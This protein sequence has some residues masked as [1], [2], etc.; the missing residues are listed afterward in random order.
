MSRGPPHSKRRRR[1]ATAF[2]ELVSTAL[3]LEPAARMRLAERRLASLDTS[4]S[5][6][7]EQ[8]WAEEAQRH[9]EQIAAGRLSSRPAEDVFRDAQ[10]RL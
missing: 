2:D 7:N 5:G 4:L 10:S 8:A 3:T 1:S 6:E 9:A